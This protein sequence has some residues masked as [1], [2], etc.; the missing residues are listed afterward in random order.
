[1]NTI[2]LDLSA[3]ITG[4]SFSITYKADSDENSVICSMGKYNGTEL[5]T[6]Y[7]IRNNK[8]ICRVGT[9]D[10]AIVD[11][12]VNKLLTIDLNVSKETNADIWYFNIF[13]DGVCSSPIRV[14]SYDWKFGFPMTLGCRNNNGTLTDYSNVKIY[15]VKIYTSDLPDVAIVQNYISA[16]E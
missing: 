15:D 7:E 2:S 6:G 1:M 11:L 13:I 8:V 10:E 5:I 16:T 4:F 3:F 14:S 9:Q 12:P